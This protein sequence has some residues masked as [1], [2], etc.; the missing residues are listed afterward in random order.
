MNGVEVTREIRRRWPEVRVVA[1]S[2][3]DD[4]ATARTMRDAGA[5]AVVSKSEDMGRLIVAI[6]H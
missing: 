5:V 3:H 4:E 2:V 6:S 1:L